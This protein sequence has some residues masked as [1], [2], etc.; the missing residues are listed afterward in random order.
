MPNKKNTKKNYYSHVSNQNIMI[1]GGI[2]I[3]SYSLYNYYFGKSKLDKKEATF[4]SQWIES[5]GPELPGN[6]SLEVKIN[7]TAEKGI[8]FLSPNGPNNTWGQFKIAGFDVPIKDTDISTAEIVQTDN[9]NLA[10]TFL[11]SDD[12]EGINGFTIPTLT[13]VLYPTKKGNY[14]GFTTSGSDLTF[15]L[16]VPGAQPIKYLIA[17]KGSLKIKN[18]KCSKDE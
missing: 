18:K 13:Y 17:G 3:A 15:T 10:V 14:K 5:A 6:I 1:G 4:T 9:G 11:F 2:L 16:P 12:V 7:K 8:Y